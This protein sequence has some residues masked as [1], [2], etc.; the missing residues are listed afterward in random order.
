MEARRQDADPVSVF[1]AAA[2]AAVAAAPQHKMTPFVLLSN[3]LIFGTPTTCCS[4]L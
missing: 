3:R 4:T 2:A 1:P